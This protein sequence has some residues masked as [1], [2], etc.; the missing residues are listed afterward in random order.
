MAA[1]GGAQVR[2]SPAVYRHHSDGRD[3]GV[4]QLFVPVHKPLEELGHLQAVLALLAFVDSLVRAAVVRCTLSEK[5]GEEK[6][7]SLKR[8]NPRWWNKICCKNN[9]LEGFVLGLQA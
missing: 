1:V 8:R 9:R 7:S 2:H 3:Q 4:G 6:G 5:E